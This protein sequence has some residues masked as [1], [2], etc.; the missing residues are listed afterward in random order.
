MRKEVDVRASPPPSLSSS[1]S[2]ALLPRAS[3]L[4]LGAPR[5]GK[6]V[7]RIWLTQ[8]LVH[9]TTKQ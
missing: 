1:F 7:E 2:G 5:P 3:L 4:V 9:I 6:K 8:Y